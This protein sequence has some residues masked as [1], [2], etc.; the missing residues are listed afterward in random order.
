MKDGTQERRIT[1][2]LDLTDYAPEFVDGDGNPR[3]VQVWVNPP[4]SRYLRFRMLHEH[5]KRLT[6]LGKRT[7][8]V[9]NGRQFLEMYTTAAGE[10]ADWWATL[11]S[12]HTDPATHWTAAEVMD[13]AIADSHFYDWLTAQSLRLIREHIQGEY[14]K[15]VLRKEHVN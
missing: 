12:Q 7:D 13:L 9:T 5:V 6:K 14:A 1:A 2:P 10:I 4:Q 8:G 11:W 15:L 3:V